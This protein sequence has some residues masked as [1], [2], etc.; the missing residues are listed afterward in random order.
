M[1]NACILFEWEEEHGYGDKC[2]KDLYRIVIEYSFQ[3]P[4]TNY[5]VEKQGKDALGEKCWK[6]LT[7]IEILND[8]LRSL[9]SCVWRGEIE[10]VKNK[11]SEA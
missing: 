10:M 9:F 8:A 2:Y 6:R 7:E 3:G 1:A 11:H 4:G 5:I